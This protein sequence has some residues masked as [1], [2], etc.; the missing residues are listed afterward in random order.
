MNAAEFETSVSALVRD[1]LR[2][3]AAE[4]G[5]AERLGRLERDLRDQIT[6]FRAG[7]RVD[8]ERLHARST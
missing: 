1:I 2:E 8:R 3:I 5:G 6:M 7:D 4:E